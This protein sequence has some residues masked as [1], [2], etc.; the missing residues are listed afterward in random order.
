M[1]AIRTKMT[2]AILATTAA[3]SGLGL[4]ATAPNAEAAATYPTAQVQAGVYIRACASTA[5]VT[6]GTVAGSWYSDTQ[7]SWVSCYADGGWATGNYRT[8]R[9]FRVYVTAAGGAT[10]WGFVHASYVYDQ[11]VVGRC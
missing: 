6:Q 7:P 2:V 3:F 5:C 8:N 4:V 1:G 9:W 11:P 10:F